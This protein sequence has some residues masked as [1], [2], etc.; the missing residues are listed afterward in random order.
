MPNKKQ[1]LPVRFTQVA[2]FTPQMFRIQTKLTAHRLKYRIINKRKGKKIT[3]NLKE[4]FDKFPIGGLEETK[5]FDR[6]NQ[7]VTLVKY[8]AIKDEVWAWIEDKLRE[9][10]IAE[11]KRYVKQISDGF[12]H[13]GGILSIVFQ[14]RIKEL[15]KK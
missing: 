9:A 6:T 4:E 8:N 2:I 15:V 11:N 14:N 5:I 13:N 10:R 7:T 1:Y 12:G 3:M